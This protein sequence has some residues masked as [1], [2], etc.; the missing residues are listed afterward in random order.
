MINGGDLAR[1][2]VSNGLCHQ[3]TGGSSFKFK[4]RQQ[5]GWWVGNGHDG[6][7]KFDA[8]SQKEVAQTLVDGGD[9]TTSSE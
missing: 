1:C 8:W 7:Q 4:V 6:V 5:G 3:T 2:V 9:G